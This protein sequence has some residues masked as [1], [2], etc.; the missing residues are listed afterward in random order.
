MRADAEHHLVPRVKLDLV[1]GG[2]DLQ[3]TAPDEPG[4]DHAAGQAIGLA[5]KRGDETGLGP[6]VDLLEY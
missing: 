5:D 6:F 1:G 2:A 3:F 4:L